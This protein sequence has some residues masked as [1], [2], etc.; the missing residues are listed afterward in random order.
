MIELVA[1]VKSAFPEEH[2]DYLSMGGFDVELDNTYSDIE[3]MIIHS[4][5]IYLRA[6]A[7]SRLEPIP[8]NEPFLAVVHGKRKAKDYFETAWLKF[9]GDYPDLAAAASDQTI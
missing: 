1:G 3:K 4:I 9:S 2:L 6:L 7:N 8:V 5:G